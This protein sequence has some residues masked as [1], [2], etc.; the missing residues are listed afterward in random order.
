MVTRSKLALKYAW[1]RTTT[2]VAARTQSS[3]CRLTDMRGWLE[4]SRQNAIVSTHGDSACR[5]RFSGLD[6]RSGQVATITQSRKRGDPMGAEPYEYFVP[7]HTNTQSALKM[8]RAD[9]FESGEFNGAEFGPTTP[10]EA[11]EITDADGTRSILDI[12]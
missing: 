2:S 1:P 9:V 12:A 3:K 5:R 4:D 8:L 11:L 10:E 7:Y 6:Y